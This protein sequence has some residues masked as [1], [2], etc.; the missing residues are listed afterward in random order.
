MKYENTGNGGTG[1]VGIQ[2]VAEL[3]RSGG[4]ARVMSRSRDRLSSLPPGVEGVTGDLQDPAS[5]PAAFD[6]ID[7]L[8]LA[9][10]SRRLPQQM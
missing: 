6:G 8:F 5:L 2:V 4:S 3:L 9:T 7:A 10:A 1:T